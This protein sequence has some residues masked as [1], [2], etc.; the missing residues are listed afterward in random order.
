MKPITNFER[1]ETL[2]EFILATGMLNIDDLVQFAND[3]P[4]VTSEYQGKKQL[5]F[6]IK[7]AKD[8]TVY[9]EINTWKPTAK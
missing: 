7:R 3:N 5:P 9:L 1:K 4:D 6:N 2:P 8:N